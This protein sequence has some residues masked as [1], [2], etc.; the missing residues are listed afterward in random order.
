MKI[1]RA[2]CIL[3]LV[4]VPAMAASNNGQSSNGN[5]QFALEGASGTIQFDAR[6]QGTAHGQMTFTGTVEVSNEDVDGEGTV[7]STVNNVSLTVSFDCVRVEG[8]HAAMSGK[9]T[10]SNL[11]A[12]VGA[13]AVLAVQDNG[14]GVNEGPD[15]FTWGLYRSN[16]NH[17]IPEDAEVP[18]DIGASLTWFMS[19]SERP[20]DVPVS[21]KPSA[22]PGTVDCQSFPFGSYAF[23]DVPHGGGNIQVKP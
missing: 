17:W 7:G 3:V 14:E 22:A 20:D 10:S 19:D 18:G 21:T 8:N 15:R 16:A 5:F 2:L 4:T 12:Y 13:R 1:F 6:M 9:V 23:E 11:P